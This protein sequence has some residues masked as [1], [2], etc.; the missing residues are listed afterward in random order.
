VL[1]AFMLAPLVN[2][3]N[4]VLPDRRRWRRA[5]LVIS[6]VLLLGAVVGA[7][8]VIG[9]KV[10]EQATAFGDSTLAKELPQL[11]STWIQRIPVEEL[12]A[13]LFQQS[14]Q[15]AASLPRAA[16]RFLS[17]AGY[18]L[19]VVLVPILA[20]FFLKDAGLIRQQILELAAPGPGR[21][22]L[23]EVLTD[24]H[25]LLAQYI[26]ALVG[27]SLVAFVA[28][29]GFFTIVGVPYGILLAAL[30][31]MLEFIPVVGPLVAAAIILVV[32]GVSGAHVLVVAGFL[33]AFRLFQ[34]YVLSPQLMAQGVKLHPLLVLFGVSAGLE[35]AGI[36]GA[37]LSVPVLALAQVLFQRLR[38]G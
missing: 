16:L 15:L 8:I 19:Y 23:N 38:K 35:L 6:Y 5:G 30:A 29:S 36:A 14:G 18:L 12:R 9:T 2:W 33:G 24:A 3:L 26:R 10:V 7:G 37:F 1:F 11:A 17:V 34:D 25:L 28:L 27:L 20:F 4:R 13:Q 22:V 31:A 21:N 32:A